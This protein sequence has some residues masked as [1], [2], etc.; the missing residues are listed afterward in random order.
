V[1]SLSNGPSGV[2]VGPPACKPW[3]GVSGLNFG[4]DKIVL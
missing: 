4:G 1:L 2:I 3:G